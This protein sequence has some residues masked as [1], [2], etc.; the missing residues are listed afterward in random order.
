L[1]AAAIG[2]SG[3]VDVF[4]SGGQL[5][6]AAAAVLGV[7]VLAGRREVFERRRNR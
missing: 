5:A 1:G 7:V 6:F 2:P 4:G 3:S